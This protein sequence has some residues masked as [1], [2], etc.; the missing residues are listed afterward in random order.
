MRVL[1]REELFITETRIPTR[2][3][4]AMGTGKGI[5]RMQFPT[6]GLCQGR[7][8]SLSATRTCHPDLLL[9]PL[10]RVSAT[11]RGWV[12]RYISVHLH[13]YP[14]QEWRRGADTWGE[15]QR[16]STGHRLLT[17]LFSPPPPRAPSHWLLKRSSAKHGRSVG[18]PWPSQLYAARRCF[19]VIHPY[20]QSVGIRWPRQKRAHAPD[21]SHSL[22]GSDAPP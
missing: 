13:T 7:R 1:C 5:L 11:R 8:G 22:A 21:K 10:S 3:G 12:P 17:S 14:I 18:S 6:R 9:V 4:K 2:V 16:T 15:R 20:N 19:S